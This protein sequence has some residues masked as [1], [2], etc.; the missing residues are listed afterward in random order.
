RRL[1][2]AFA[3][4]LSSSLAAFAYGCGAGEPPLESLCDFLG[5][6]KN[7][8][9]AFYENVGDRCGAYGKGNGPVGTFLARSA[10][11]VCVL[12]KGGQVLFDPALDLTQ[13]PVQGPVNMKFINSLGD[14]CGAASFAGSYNWSLTIDSYPPDS[15]APPGTG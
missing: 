13:F 5:N 12:A 14:E 2:L 8:E 6:T 3:V 15:G 10:L 9:R 1:A 11:D 7:C 4:A